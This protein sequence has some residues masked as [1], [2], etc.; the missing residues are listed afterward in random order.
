MPSNLKNTS[1]SKWFC[2][3]FSICSVACS[4]NHERP[5][6]Q[7]GNASLPAREKTV[8]PAIIDARADST[9]QVAFPVN[10]SSVVLLGEL[11]TANQEITAN[12]PVQDK[13]K[14]TATLLP[15][16]SLPNIRFAQV[17]RPTGEADGPF[18]T[19]VSIPTPQNGTYKLRISHN[20]RTEAALTKEFKLRVVLSQ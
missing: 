12:V 19:S 13:R 8:A 3:S 4:N 17:I 14:L 15:P 5:T 7:V 9:I 2:L 10:D 18:G 16:D 1:V 6:S 20:L 11:K